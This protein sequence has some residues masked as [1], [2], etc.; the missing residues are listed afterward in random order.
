MKKLVFLILII[1]LP[2]YAFSMGNR[3]DDAGYRNELTYVFDNT[4]TGIYSSDITLLQGKEALKKLRDSYNIGYT[5]ESGVID[6]ML[7]RV[8]EGTMLPNETKYYFNLLQENKLSEYRIESYQKQFNF[9]QKEMLHLMQSM[10]GLNASSATSVSE[11]R[12]TINNYYDFFGL[13]YGQEYRI[14]NDLLILLE[15]G[16]ISVETLQDRLATMEKEVSDKTIVDASSVRGANQGDATAGASTNPDG[17]STGG[18]NVSAPNTGNGTGSG[19]RKSAG[20]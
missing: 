17:S 15:E 7:D 9:H 14:L 12:N 20:K 16:K 11:L 18:D 19:G 13:R 5:D 1:V 6:Y 10:T 4:V 2:V 3:E 8:Y